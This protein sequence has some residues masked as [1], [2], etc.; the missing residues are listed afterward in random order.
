MQISEISLKAYNKFYDFS[1]TSIDDVFEVD[2]EVRNF[3][4]S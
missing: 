2:R 3:V 1:P 4:L